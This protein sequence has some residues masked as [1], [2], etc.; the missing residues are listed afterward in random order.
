MKRLAVFCGS[1]AGNQPVYAEAAELTARE[2]AKRNI[3]LVY[4]G[5]HV[6][7]MG[8][9]ADATLEAGGSVI[10]VIPESLKSREL[11]HQGLTQLH[12][13]KD[14][15]ERKALMSDLS[16][17][18]IALPGG[19]GTMEEIFETWTWGILGYHRKPCAF[20]NVAGYFDLL[21]QFITHMEQQA[22]LQS[23]YQEMLIIDAQIQSLL[24]SLLAYQPPAIKWS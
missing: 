4:G 1:A 17:G 10:G 18:F 11:A 15:H 20:L 7:L 12:V 5:G 16:D 13:V 9:L 24:D 3:G 23:S 21:G 6:G 19:A 8:I 14:M 2:I 22:F